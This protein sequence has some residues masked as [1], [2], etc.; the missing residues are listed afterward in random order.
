MMSAAKC[1]PLTGSNYQSCCIALNRSQ[2]LTPYE[3]NQCP[4]LTTAVIGVANSPS[5]DDERSSG[6]G[7][8]PSG[9]TSG[10]GDNGGTSGGGDNGGGDNGGGDHHHDH[11]HDHDHHGGGD[12]HHGGGD[13]HHEGGDQGHNK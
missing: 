9:G 13:D 8:R 1:S 11:H 4:P 10:G 6:D 5:G 7:N 3:L 12:D 2:I